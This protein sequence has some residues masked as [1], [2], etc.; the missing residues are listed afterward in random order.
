MALILGIGRFMSM[1]HAAANMIGSGV[2]TLV[3]ARCE[4]EI[5]K[6]TLRRNL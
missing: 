2:A 3:I 4:K 5:D 6:P 1:F